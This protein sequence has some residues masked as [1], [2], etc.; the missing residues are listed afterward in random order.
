MKKFIL[1]T[2]FLLFGSQSYAKS[3]FSSVYCAKQSLEEVVKE[4]IIRELLGTSLSHHF[5]CLDEYDFKL[6]RSVWNPP[7]EGERLFQYGVVLS[8]LKILKMDLVEEFTGQYKVSFQ[9]KTTKPFGSLVLKDTI[10]IATKLSKSMHENYG[11]SITM[12]SPQKFYLASFCYKKNK[13][14]K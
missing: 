4:S 1:L 14:N 11:C 3:N 6:V 10:L 8:S 7:V 12:E 13:G 9:I 2:F 5:K